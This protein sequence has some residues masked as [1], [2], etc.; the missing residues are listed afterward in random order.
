MKTQGRQDVGMEETLTQGEDPNDTRAAR[1]R[2]A[3]EEPDPRDPANIPHK[4]VHRVQQQQQTESNIPHSRSPREEFLKV[5]VEDGQGAHSESPLHFRPASG[6]QFPTF[7]L[8]RSPGSSSRGRSSRFQSAT[9]IPSRFNTNSRVEPEIV[10]DDVISPESQRFYPTFN[11]RHSPFSPSRQPFFPSPVLPSRVPGHRGGRFIP[12]TAG[13]HLESTGP[14]DFHNSFHAGSPGGGREAFHKPDFS[15]TSSRR[16]FHREQEFENHDN[17][18]LGSG[19]FEVLSGGTFYDNDDPNLHH[20]EYDH[21]LGDGY[22]TFPGVQSQPHTNNYVDDFFSNFRDFSE[23]AARK[24]DEGESTTFL[25]EEPYFTR[26]FASEHIPRQ[27]AAESTQHLDTSSGILVQ[28]EGK[29]TQNPNK[30]THTTSP[31]KKLS[32]DTNSTTTT[33]TT[34]TTKPHKHR[35]PKNI[36]DVLDEVDPRPS[37]HTSTTI[38]IDE[39]DPMIAM[40]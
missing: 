18:L 17:S 16:P 37:E 3:S 40:F 38:D 21:L 33:K 10:Q 22:G 32:T 11:G 23:F 29:S 35:Q 36:Q 31:D 8:G 1:T 39:K 19:N 28:K 12:H 27:V 9:R 6:F 13:H 15:F 20:Q 30:I 14:R 26:G 34:T 7:Q 2:R 4:R 24:S 25:D 5:V